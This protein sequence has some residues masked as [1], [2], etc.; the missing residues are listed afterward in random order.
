MVV[1]HRAVVPWAQWAFAMV[2]NAEASSSIKS[3]S[4]PPW[5]WISTK[6]AII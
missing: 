1:G 5:T 4:P 3:E 6:P 2:G